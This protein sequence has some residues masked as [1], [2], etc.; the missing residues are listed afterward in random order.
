MSK[1]NDNTG[2]KKREFFKVDNPEAELKGI[3][4][5]VEKM[6]TQEIKRRLPGQLIKN[7]Y[8]S[9]LL[10]ERELSIKQGKR[11]EKAADVFI[12]LNMNPNFWKNLKRLEEM[13][14]EL[15]KKEEEDKVEWLDKKDGKKEKNKQVS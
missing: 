9:L 15:P 13:A 5:E 8:A 6:S 4:E 1:T 12:K 2:P 14:A 7:I 3:F 11:R 10:L